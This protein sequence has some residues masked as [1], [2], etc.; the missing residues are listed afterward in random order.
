MTIQERRYQLP[1]AAPQHRAGDA[2]MRSPVSACPVADGLDNIGPDQRAYAEEADPV[3]QP[4]PLPTHINSTAHVT[5]SVPPDHP[6][7]FTV[8]RK[9]SQKSQEAIA[10]EPQLLFDGGP[11]EKTHE[12]VQKPPSHLSSSSP[13][14]AASTGDDAAASTSDMNSAGR[15]FQLQKKRKKSSDV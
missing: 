2:S 5:R 1:A 11:C 3:P 14:R 13:S 9:S 12:I 4:M 6:G 7:L 15:L 8:N 10:A